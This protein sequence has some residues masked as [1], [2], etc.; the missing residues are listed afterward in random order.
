MASSERIRKYRKRLNA[1][2]VWREE[3]LRKRRAKSLETFNLL[4]VMQGGLQINMHTSH[5]LILECK[6]KCNP[7]PLPRKG[8]AVCAP[9]P[10]STVVYQAISGQDVP[11]FREKN[12]LAS[13]SR[14]S[15]CSRNPSDS[16]QHPPGGCPPV[17]GSNPPTLYPPGL[18][19]RWGL[20]WSGV[21]LS[22][23]DWYRSSWPPNRNPGPRRED[24]HVGRVPYRVPVPSFWVTP[25]LKPTTPRLIG[26]RDESCL[27]VYTVCPSVCGPLVSSGAWA[28]VRG[29]TS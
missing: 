15:S 8:Y 13:N 25:G 7:S 24:T 11:N 1:D 2:C 29:R 23:E 21:G 17:A 3:V 16:R 10:V 9:V 28:R 5:S 12:G 27:G 6:S 4:I 20:H 14:D 22:I 19:R 26:E 18:R